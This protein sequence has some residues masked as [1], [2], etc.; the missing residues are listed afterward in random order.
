[1][2]QH[3][4]EHMIV[5]DTSYDHKATEWMGTAQVRFSEGIKVRIVSVPV[6]AAHFKS[7]EEAQE[8]AILAARKWIDHRL[9]SS[10]GP[11]S[12]KKKSTSAAIA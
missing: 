12:S 2:E 9:Q 6:P 4:R 11:F 5:Y 1:M 7:K 10:S 8:G 3:Y